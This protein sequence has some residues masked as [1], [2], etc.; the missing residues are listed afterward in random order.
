MKQSFPTWTDKKLQEVE[1]R[2][3]KNLC[4]S[5]VEVVKLLTISES[6]LNK[7]MIANWDEINVHIKDPSICQAYL[8]H[9]F[10]WE[11]GTVVANWNLNKRFT[12][13]YQ[14]LS[15]KV[16][17]RITAKIRTRSGT[18]IV[19]VRS[20][21]GRLR[22]LQQSDIVWGFIADQNPSDPKRVSWNDFLGRKT[23]FAKGAEFVARRY[24]NKVF[25]GEIIKLKRGYYEIKLNLAFEKAKETADG[26]ITEAYV[27]FLEKSIE[28]QPENW[29]WS[30]RRWKHVFPGS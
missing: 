26:E 30:H 14:P 4:D 20:L 7:R 6:Q 10:N 19:P 2:F 17:E 27:R 29:V 1:R 11:W 5:I 13:V 18:D 8:A 12:G 16:F 25:F 9:Q 23:A 28:R 21:L 22:S 24:N 15:S 3:Y